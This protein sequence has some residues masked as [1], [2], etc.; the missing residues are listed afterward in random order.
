MKEKELVN[1][2]KALANKRRL[3]ILSTLKKKK[4]L[5]VGNLANE[6]KLSIRSTSKHLKILSMA[7]MVEHEQQSKQIFYR[8]APGFSRLIKDIV[9]G[10]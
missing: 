7:D 3:L 6:I 9:G 5:S 4:E 2:F 10:L 8:V 1:L